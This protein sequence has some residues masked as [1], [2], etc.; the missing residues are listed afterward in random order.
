MGEGKSVDPRFA[1][2]AS[3]PGSKVR[4]PLNLHAY[5]VARWPATSGVR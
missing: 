2:T 3:R 5:A 1:G 4:P